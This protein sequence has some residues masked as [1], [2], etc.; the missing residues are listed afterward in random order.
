MDRNLG[1]M[2]AANSVASRGLY[3]QWGRKDPIP[4]NNN[5]IT[6]A[7]GQVSMETAIRN[8][9]TFFYKEETYDWLST[10]NDNLW[11]GITG[12]KSIYD[13][14]PAGFKVPLVKVQIRPSQASQINPIRTVTVA[15]PVRRGGHLTGP[16]RALIAAPPES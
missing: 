14:S 4:L 6:F 2:E 9:N 1:A 7:N 15:I 16:L 8:P 10:P 3:Y 12:T 11:G 13:P 5:L